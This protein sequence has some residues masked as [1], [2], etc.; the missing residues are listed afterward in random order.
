MDRGR[1][2]FAPAVLISSALYIAYHLPFDP[3]FAAVW[4]NL[5]WNLIGLFLLVRS[6]SL[7]PPM[8]F[9]A[10]IN[11]VAI[12]FSWGYYRFGA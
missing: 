6:G 9:H 4:F 12:F 8:I 2:W 10:A 7:F 1:G 11:Y 3:S 5:V